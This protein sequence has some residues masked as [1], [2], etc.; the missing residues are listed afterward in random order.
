MTCPFWG[1]SGR[2]L[3]RG[4]DEAET[5]LGYLEEHSFA[6]YESGLCWQGKK[7]GRR[8]FPLNTRPPKDSRLQ[9]NQ[10]TLRNL[11]EDGWNRDENN[12]TDLLK[13]NLAIF[14]LG[15]YV[16]AFA[17]AVSFEVTMILLT[18]AVSVVC[19][20]LLRHPEPLKRY[21]TVDSK[22][23]ELWVSTK[24]FHSGDHP[25]NSWCFLY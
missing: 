2:Q 16:V 14:H 6:C 23:S 11:E 21:L 13:L 12:T 8:I 3:L 1:A 25:L 24:G 20:F 17:G 7:S 9:R 10:R 18:A 15:S 22:R 5:C 4:I 19:A